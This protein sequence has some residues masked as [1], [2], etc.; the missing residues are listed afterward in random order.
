MPDGKKPWEQYSKEST[1]QKPWEKYSSEVKKKESSQPTSQED[2]WG[3]NLQ[4]KDVYTSLVTDQPTLQQVSDTSNGEQPKMRTLGVDITAKEALTSN[5]SKQEE[6]FSGA[7][8]Y[9]KK[10]AIQKELANTKV[11]VKNQDEVNKKIEEVS[12][13]DKQIKQVEAEKL[14]SIEQEFYNSQ[15]RASAEVEASERLDNLLNNNGIWNNVKSFAKNAYN[16]VI[17]GV[18]GSNPLVSSALS[19][20]VDTDPLADEKNEVKKQ[21]LKDGIKLSSE[22]I[23]AKAKDLFKSK[24]VENIE[25]DRINSFLDD[26]P[27]EDRLLLKQDRAQKITHLQDSNIKESKIINAFETVGNQKI[28]EYKTLENQLRKIKESGQQIP[29]DL[30]NKYI[31]LG[32]EI[33]NIASDIKKRQDVI[34]K[35][36]QDLGTVE[37]E[38]DFFK[39][40]YGDIENFISN[41]AITAEELGVNLVSGLDYLGS[42]MNP[43]TQASSLQLQ[44]K[45]SD[46]NKELSNQRNTLRKSVQS[47]ES[48][49]G[50]VN[51]ASDI[52]ANQLPNLALTSTGSGGLALMGLASAGQKNTEMNSEVLSGK[53]SY[54]PFQMAAAPL[55]YGAAEV[56]SEIP[57]LE[58]LRNGGRLLD[59]V[60]KNESHLITKTA[61]QKGKEF[62][63]EWGKDLSSELAGEEFTNFAQN[64][65]DKY[66]LGK[67]DVGLLDNTGTVFKDT[68][69]LTAM[70]KS[71]PH[72]AGA[73]LKPFQS[74]NDLNVLDENAKKIIDL[75]KA[76]NTLNLSDKEKSIIQQQINKATTENSVIMANTIENIANMPNDVYLKINELNDKAAKLKSDAGVINSGS[77]PNKAELLKDLENQYKD[78]QIERSNLINTKYE[79]GQ[80]EEIVPATKSEL[81]PK[82]KQ[83][84]L[85]S[86]EITPKEYV[87]ELTKTK[88]SDPEAFWTVDNVTEEAA[89]NGTIVNTED[90]AALVSKDGDIKGVFKKLGSEA[91]GVAQDLLAKAVEAGGIKLD[92]F[93]GY[94][95]KLYEKAGF[96][97]ASRVPFNEEY[98]PEGWNKEKH[99]TPDVVAMVYDPNGELDIEEKTFD[100][101]DEAM[102]YR[103]QYANQVKSDKN[104]VNLLNEMDQTKGISKKKSIAKNIVDNHLDSIID[105]LEKNNQLKKIPCR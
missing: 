25:T 62:A 43:M 38:F 99:G 57:T 35:N 15:D 24:Q 70:L 82:E 48:P 105:N 58:I 33:K 14:K 19:L 46:I 56:V 55:L 30:Y 3:S 5:K 39:R 11:T 17:S 13:L 73:V 18:A 37:Q 27:E 87:K 7:K 69:T 74:K 9:I 28:N 29:E 52:M 22:E 95:T 8:P 45:L 93:D 50:F 103:D 42:K 72:I 23:N 6:S 76:L 60:I 81:I 91:K 1:N 34:L 59:S 47:I 61:L 80:N 78:I 51:Y 49:E 12:A 88:Q 44:S 20:A 79:S 86:T 32:S 85:I 97:V 104:L 66:V 31:G 90:G 84:S 67:K 100:D 92:N 4:P 102:A 94:L 53:A 65:N 36:K 10:K 98:A 63:K 54:S 101:Y 89:Q 2:V 16:N 68:L 96:R 26:L 71:S 75:S 64:F 77:L 83:T 21:A 41:A 40:N